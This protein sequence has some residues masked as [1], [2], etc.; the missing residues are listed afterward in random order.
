M[1]IMISLQLMLGKEPLTALWVLETF[2]F[3]MNIPEMQENLCSLM[4]TA[5]KIK[6]KPPGAYPGHKR[7]SGN[8]ENEVDSNIGAP[9]KSR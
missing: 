6:I 5:M 2:L 1:I 4:K 3:L 7:D 9:S 8:G